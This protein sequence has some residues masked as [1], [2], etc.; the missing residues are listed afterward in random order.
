MKAAPM[1]IAKKF[2]HKAQAV[3]GRVKKTADRLT[4]AGACAPRAAPTGSSA[5]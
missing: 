2:A 3:K 4:A 1:S 5:T